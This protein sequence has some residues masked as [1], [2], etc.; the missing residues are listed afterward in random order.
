MTREATLSNRMEEDLLGSREVPADA[1]YGIQTMRGLENFHISGVPLSHYPEL[2]EALAMIKMAAARANW[3]CGQ[4]SAE[5]AD[6]IEATCRELIGGQF[7]DQFQLD[8]FQPS[9]QD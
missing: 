5:I 8:V 3:D 9:G 7:H 4:F 6:A 1:S 2:I